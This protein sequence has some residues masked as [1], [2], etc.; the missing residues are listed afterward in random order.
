MLIKFI[1]NTFNK[2]TTNGFLFWYN[3]PVDLPASVTDV[4]SKIKEVEEFNGR[5]N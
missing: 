2:R 3:V 4:E 5:D 1:E